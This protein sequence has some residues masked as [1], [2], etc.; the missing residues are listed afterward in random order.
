MDRK[1]S[2]ADFGKFLEDMNRELDKLEFQNYDP[3]NTVR[4]R[5]FGMN[6]YFH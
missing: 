6:F 4:T 1:L 2:S 5:S 3:N